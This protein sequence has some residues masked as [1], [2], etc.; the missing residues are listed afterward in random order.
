MVQQAKVDIFK[1]AE[2]LTADEQNLVYGK[3]GLTLTLHL[4]LFMETTNTLLSYDVTDMQDVHNLCKKCN[5]CQA[6][7]LKTEGCD[8]ETVCGD[9]P[10]TT[11]RRN[12]GLKVSF[13]RAGNAWS[14][15]YTLNGIHQ[16]VGGLTGALA[17]MLSSAK[18][19]GGTSRHTRKKGYAWASGCGELISWNTM[20][21]VSPDEMKQLGDIEAL[22][23]CTH[24]RVSRE[25]FEHRLKLHEIA[26]WETLETF[27][28]KRD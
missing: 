20:I 3:A 27:L 26:N 1:S 28:D 4:K 16:L 22:Q 12:A 13:V 18:R 21:P 10:T 19:S 11:K 2:D 5:F 9:V 25:H 24:E 23:I 17:A 6:I 8:G 7:F 15:V 14:L